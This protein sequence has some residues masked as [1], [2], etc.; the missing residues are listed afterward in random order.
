MSGTLVIRG[1]VRTVQRKILPGLGVCNLGD[2][3]ERP[4]GVFTLPVTGAVDFF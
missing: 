2:P 1:I 3:D 4:F